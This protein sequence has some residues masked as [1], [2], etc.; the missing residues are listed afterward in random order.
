MSV[1]GSFVESPKGTPDGQSGQEYHAGLDELARQASASVA[2]VKKTEG[3]IKDNQS[4]VEGAKADSKR[5]EAGRENKASSESEVSLAAVES[6][7]LPA[8]MQIAKTGMEVLG[9]NRSNPVDT[10]SNNEAKNLGL[11]GK[12]TSFEDGFKTIRSAPLGNL[13]S[14]PQRAKVASKSLGEQGDTNIGTVATEQNAANLTTSATLATSLVCANE[15]VLGQ[16]MAAKATNAHNINHA[17]GMGSSAPAL[18]NN[19]MGRGPA[20][21]SPEQAERM[22]RSMET[23]NSE[24]WA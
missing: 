1:S 7:A 3:Q 6:A 17:P 9:E 5:E 19:K 10:L 18:E 2:E 13:N 4:R 21:I 22:A 20:Y 8:A 11:S 23:D 24:S 14:I 15:K 12:G 16:V